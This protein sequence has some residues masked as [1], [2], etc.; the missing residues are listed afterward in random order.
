M[1]AE[2]KN[3]FCNCTRI[4]KVSQ[5]CPKIPEKRINKTKYFN[6]ICTYFFY[7]HS[8]PSGTIKVLRFQFLRQ[9]NLLGNGQQVAT[10]PPSIQLR[11]QIHSVGQIM[12]SCQE[13]FFVCRCHWPASWLYKVC[14]LGCL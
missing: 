1:Q 2:L 11:K 14:L 5:N 13:G 3:T 12:L 4:K 8:F 10:L 6:F 7:E 9:L